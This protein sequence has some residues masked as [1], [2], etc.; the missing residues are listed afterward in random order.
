VKEL[1]RRGKEVERDKIYKFVGER[2]TE[3]ERERNIAKRTRESVKRKDFDKE[4][5]RGERKLFIE[6]VKR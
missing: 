3:T 5:R 6:G 4:K 2:E 1:Y